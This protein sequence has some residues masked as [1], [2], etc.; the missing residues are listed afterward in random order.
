MLSEHFVVDEFRCGSGE[1]VPHELLPNLRRLV[2]EVLEPIRQRWGAIIVVS[3]Y[4]SPAYNEALFRASEARA[5]AAGRAHGGVAQRSQHLTASAADIR[6]VRW[7]D[8]ELLGDVVDNLLAKG[9]LRALGGF[10]R[11]GSW[12]HCDVRPRVN[13][14]VVRW[15]GSGVGSEP[16]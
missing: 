15:L 13:G 10:G 11:Y 9:E 6:P 12:I 4:R 5:K 3:G 16:G 2:V 7:S 1:P 14:Q 8:V